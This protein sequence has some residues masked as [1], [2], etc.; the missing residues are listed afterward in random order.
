MQTKGDFANKGSTE[1]GRLSTVGDLCAYQT[2]RRRQGGM[3][4][5]GR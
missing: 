4:L 5:F 2:Q 1:Y 3:G